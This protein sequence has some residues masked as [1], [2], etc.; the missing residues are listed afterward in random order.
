MQNIPWEGC[1]LVY[2]IIPQ[3]YSPLV[4]FQYFIIM[5]SVA[6]LFTYNFVHLHKHFFK[7]RFLNW[8]YHDGI[9]KK[10]DIY[11]QIVIPQRLTIYLL[12][13]LNE[14]EHFITKIRYFQSF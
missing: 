6:I 4:C 8:N 13:I 9:N 7:T 2:A 14:S 12:G 1:T 10:L 5:N 3:Q 11:G